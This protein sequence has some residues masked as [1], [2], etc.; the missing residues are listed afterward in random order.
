MKMLAAM[1]VLRPRRS[2]SQPPRSPNTPPHRAAI[3][4]VRPIHVV[5]SGS[6]GPTPI[7]S[8]RASA[9][10]AGNIKSS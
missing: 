4:S 10:I 3:H 9:P 8:A 7:N 2:I 1:T 6:R 5:T